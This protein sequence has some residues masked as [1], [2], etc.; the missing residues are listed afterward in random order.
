MESIQ[1]EGLLGILSEINKKI[2]AIQTNSKVKEIQPV[3]QAAN[4][5]VSKEEMEAITV[6][7]ANAM[8]KY[9]EIRHK[10]QTE[11]QNRLLSAVQG[12]KRQINALPTSEKVSLE[13]IL[14]LLPQPKKVAL[15]GFEFL[16][17][18]LVIFILSVALLWSLTMNI[19]QMDNYRMLKIKLYQQT[20]YIL[21]LQQKEKK[22]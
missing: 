4:T 10:E 6:K 2:D 16:R 14:K 13:P 7:Y 18:S 21:H 5:T 11:H 19:K 12:V 22:K 9:M 20:E 1:Y 3:N 15:F 17:T 8:G